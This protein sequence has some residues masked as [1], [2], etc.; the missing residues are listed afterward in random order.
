MPEQDQYPVKDSAHN[1]TGRER[2]CGPRNTQQQQQQQ[3]LQLQLQLQPQQLTCSVLE[4]AQQIFQR[5]RW[6]ASWHTHSNTCL[7]RGSKGRP[8][9][10]RRQ[11][12]QN[13]KRPRKTADT[14]KAPG[15]A[16]T[17]EHSLSQGLF[18]YGTSR[19]SL[20]HEATKPSPLL[21]GVSA[22]ETAPPPP[23]QDSSHE[24]SGRQDET[25]LLHTHTQS[26]SQSTHTAQQTRT[27]VL[28]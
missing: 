27:T 5:N 14:L 3:Q 15:F 26:T 1:Y 17:L 28:T 6:H 10:G 23:L 7:S 21:V 20:T 12:A 18:F 25:R 9:S 4:I 13:E 2:T 24:V 16:R 19:L 22:A 11:P 8:A